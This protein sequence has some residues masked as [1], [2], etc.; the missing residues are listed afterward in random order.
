MLIPFSN[1]NFHNFQLGASDG[2]IKT[3]LFQ[4]PSGKK[5]A[6]T[7][8]S[9]FHFGAALP[10]RR[11]KINGGDAPGNLRDD[12]DVYLFPIRLRLNACG[13][14]ISPLDREK[15]PSTL[16]IRLRASRVG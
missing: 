7:L 16:G 12:A 15:W 1:F 13:L 11:K 8:E 4:A 5:S 14:A 9:L 6:V 3:S 10:M 2:C